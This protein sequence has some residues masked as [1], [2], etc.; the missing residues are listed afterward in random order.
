MHTDPAP[1]P[2]HVDKPADKVQLNKNVFFSED[3]PPI[4]GGTIG[5]VVE[6]LF[7]IRQEHHHVALLDHDR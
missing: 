3:D 1:P 6:M 5:V 7:L 4:S 2:G